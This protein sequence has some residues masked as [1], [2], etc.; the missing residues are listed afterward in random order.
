M[1][2]SDV[3]I[4]CKL[5]AFW[6]REVIQEL[7]QED[8]CGFIPARST[9]FNLRRL[10][11][12]LHKT[13]GADCDIELGSIDLE[14]AFDTVAWHYVMVVLRGK[15]FGIAFRNWVKLLYTDPRVHLRMVGALSE[16]G[17]WEGHLAG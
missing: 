9:A 16:L 17:G 10:I 15:G 2:N 3:E 8:Q 13:V 5:L 7:V 6:L 4:L 14:K 1:I 12:V 11:R